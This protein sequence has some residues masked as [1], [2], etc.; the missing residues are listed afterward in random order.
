MFGFKPECPID[1]PTR[2]WIDRR[3]DW[4]TREFG[5]ERLRSAQVILP[6]PEFF[7]DAYSGT[8]DDVRVMLDRVCEFMD[9]NPDSIEL[10]IYRERRPIHGAGWHE[11]AAGLYHE[12]DGKY[13][14]EIE[15]ANIDDPQRL[16][17]TIAHELGHVHLL[18][19]GRI[20]PETEDHEPLTDLLTVFLGLGVFTANSVIHEKYWRAGEVSGWSIG[21]QGYL[22]MPMYGYALA[23]FTLA[24]WDEQPPWAKL[25]RPDVRSPF[26]KSLRFLAAPPSDVP[27][28]A[29]IAPYTQKESIQ[30]EP[31]ESEE[32]QSNQDSDD[33]PPGEVEFPEIPG[34]AEELLK[35]YAR[36][37]RDFR[38]INLSGASLREADLRGS[39][40][41]GADLSEVDMSF[42][43]LTGCDLHG[44]YLHEAVLRGAT[45][46]N[47]NLAEA[48]LNGADLSDADLT[49]AD[50]RG[51]D[52]RR[53]LLDGANLTAT[54]RSRKTDLSNVDISKVECDVDLSQEKLVG[55]DVSNRVLA[56][57]RWI[58]RWLIASVFVGFVAMF[59]AFFGAFIGFAIG[60]KNATSIGALFGAI[61][62]GSLFVRRL[63]RLGA[64]EKSEQQSK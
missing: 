42:A 51:A 32:E 3:W 9:L 61:L 57:Q 48:D 20:D 25:L 37:D 5:S 23:K 13:Q 40:L 64:K 36:G 49:G 62:F 24:R 7:P 4:L 33:S 31:D 56:L 8:E 43:M 41:A 53:T 17:A 30:E 21:R 52:F 28:S 47:A 34:S 1:P 60:D 11:G 54:I 35:R 58:G 44:A 6:S 12:E 2:E 45:L 59:G 26:T 55:G 27:A 18:G 14:I 50:I 29:P 15:A 16:V 19:H 46:R 39:N 38:S 22:T 63:V 10:S